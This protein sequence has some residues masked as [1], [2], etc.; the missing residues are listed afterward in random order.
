MGRILDGALLCNALFPVV[1]IIDLLALCFFFIL[2]FSRPS[3]DVSNN[4]D[5]DLLLLFSHFHINL[6]DLKQVSIYVNFML[7]WRKNWD[8]RFSFLASLVLWLGI[9]AVRSWTFFVFLSYVLV[10][11]VKNW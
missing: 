11:P 3:Y 8:T 10:R 1:I 9:F 6:L 4:I 7:L 2:F 5:E